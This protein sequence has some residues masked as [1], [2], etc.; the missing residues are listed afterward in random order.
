MFIEPTTNER[1]KMQFKSPPWKPKPLFRKT[2]EGNLKL[3]L[4]HVMSEKVFLSLEAIHSE[5]SARGYRGGTAA[6]PTW[7]RELIY[8][9]H[10]FVWVEDHLIYLRPHLCY[11]CQ[12]VYALAC[13]AYRFDLDARISALAR[14]GGMQPPNT[15]RTVKRLLSIGLIEIDPSGHIIPLP[16]T[17]ALPELEVDPES[18]VDRG[19]LMYTKEEGYKATP[20][21]QRYKMPRQK[22]DEVAGTDKDITREPNPHRVSLAKALVTQYAKDRPPADTRGLANRLV[23]ETKL[24]GGL[25]SA[26]VLPFALWDFMWRYPQLASDLKHEYGLPQHVIQFLPRKKRK[27]RNKNK[28]T[29][30]TKTR[31]KTRRAAKGVQKPE[32]ALSQLRLALEGGLANEITENENGT[33]SKHPFCVI[34]TKGLNAPLREWWAEGQLA[35]ICSANKE[36]QLADFLNWIISDQCTLMHVFDIDP[37]TSLTRRHTQIPQKGTQN[38]HHKDTT[39]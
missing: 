13:V 22:L 17:P 1:L 39:D 21:W 38:E 10:D 24:T 7:I 2:I 34:S 32:P 37:R 30:E 16:A 3:Q 31:D 26:C 5:Y 8:N 36:Q 23:R 29:Q 15:H 4:M 33:T 18:L 6:V 14:L 20:K 12:Y 35:K 9:R 27:P 11:S 28:G 19:I 25:I